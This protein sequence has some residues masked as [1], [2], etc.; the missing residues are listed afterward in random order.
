MTDQEKLQ[1]MAILASAVMGLLDQYGASIVPYLVDSDDNTGEYLR[2]AVRTV[3]G[4]DH[5]SPTDLEVAVAREAFD[6]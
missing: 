1:H 2:Q 6:D 4:P 5:A 3:L